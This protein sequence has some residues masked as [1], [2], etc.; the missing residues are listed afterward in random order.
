M[1]T[2]LLYQL[3]ASLV[4]VVLCFLGLWWFG[5]SRYESGYRDA[6]AK[7]IVHAQKVV[8][9]QREVTTKVVTKYVPQLRVVYERGATIT[10]KV[11]VYVTVKD[12]RKCVVNTGFVQL[13]NSA[14]SMHVPNTP[15]AVDETPSPVKLSEIAAE[16][17]RESTVCAA[18]QL[19]L[20][21]LQEWI[22][23]QQ[24]VAH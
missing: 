8:K 12:N 24:K 18:T 22:Q 23:A 5:H 7:S 14:N 13:W 16:H 4:A 17:A 11:P 21:T 1:P 20:T 19:Q 3:V 9:I 10:K 2:K 15:T 6:V